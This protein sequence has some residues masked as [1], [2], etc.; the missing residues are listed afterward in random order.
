M[1][2]DPPD[3][4]RS[5]PATVGSLS[6]K[7]GC[8]P[9]NCTCHFSLPL[10]PALPARGPWGING[11]IPDQSSLVWW[12]PRGLRRLPRCQDEVLPISDLTRTPPAQINTVTFLCF[13][14]PD[15]GLAAV[16]VPTNPSCDTA[17]S[18]GCLE[19]KNHRRSD[20]TVI[21]DQPMQGF[22]FKR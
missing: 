14:F 12:G 13:D 6:S 10:M 7:P 8:S 16:C 11:H 3:S 18:P 9:S 15:P 19:F 2:G 1:F 20:R 17:F 21:S 22:L 4:L 5:P